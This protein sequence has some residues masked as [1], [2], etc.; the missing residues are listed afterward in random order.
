MEKIKNASKI[1]LC[2]ATA[3]EK[4][5]T[6][7]YRKREFTDSDLAIIGPKVTREVCERYNYCALEWFS[8]VEGNMVKKI[9][10]TDEFPI[11]M[12][13]NDAELKIIYM[14]NHPNSSLKYMLFGDRTYPRNIYGEEQ[15]KQAQQL[16]EEG[17]AKEPIVMFCNDDNDALNMAGLGFFPLWTPSDQ[18][19][20]DIKVLMK[21]IDGTKK[22][23]FS[24][25]LKKQI[26]ETNH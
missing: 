6:F 26:N 14:P 21:M 1:E 7:S 15:L 13:E 5:G 11:F 2:E 22:I 18:V 12:R 19:K 17:K 9:I 20:I 3:E 16:Y 10:S 25:K 4:Q 23:E 24:D 8:I